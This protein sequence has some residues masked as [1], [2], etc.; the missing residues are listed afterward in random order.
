[1][2]KEHKQNCDCY[3]C[4]AGDDYLYQLHMKGQ[5]AQYV[6]YT[7]RPIVRAPMFQGGALVESDSFAANFN[8]DWNTEPILANP[9]TFWKDW[10]SANTWIKWH[11]KVKE[12]YGPDRANQVLIEWFQKAPFGSPTTDFRTF[13]DNFI[14]YAKDNGFYEALFSGLGGLVGKVA[15]AGV[16]TIDAGK[17]VVD[18]AGNV[19]TGAAKAI[20][21]VGEITLGIGKY[22]KWIILGAVII[23][24]I[25]LFS[26]AK[27]YVN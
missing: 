25:L 12:K 26:K 22:F 24:A 14:K 3:Q 8:P 15:T 20:E 1:M 13:D 18:A 27:N 19:V 11:T 6:D 10:W 21:N 16:K 2:L 5:K 17:T 9:L 23:G 4:K 7:G